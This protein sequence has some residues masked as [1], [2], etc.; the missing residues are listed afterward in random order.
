MSG[1]IT[2]VCR[3]CGR[4]TEDGTTTCSQHKHGGGRQRPCVECGTL[5]TGAD[6]CREHEGLGEQRR[7]EAQ[8]YRTGYKTP[9]YR[10]NR[11]LRYEMAG[12]CCEGCG[13][14]VGKGEWESHHVISLREWER[15]GLPGDGDQV[16]NL[17]IL[18]VVEPNACHHKAKDGCR[19]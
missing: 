10:R 2:K 6:Y 19:D 11:L 9:A 17:E 14:S 5:T 7:Q 12:G 16:E 4:Q 3:V 1:R 8:S 13:R 15:R 18:C